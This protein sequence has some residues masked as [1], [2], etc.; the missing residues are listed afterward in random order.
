MGRFR[1][2]NPDMYTNEAQQEK[3]PIQTVLVATEYDFEW[4]KTQVSSIFM[5]FNVS[6]YKADFMP[7]RTSYVVANFWLIFL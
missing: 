5:L 3:A 4:I 7:Y 2:L 1:K 6:N